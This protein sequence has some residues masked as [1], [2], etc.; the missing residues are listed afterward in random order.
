MDEDQ[1]PAFT[2]SVNSLT[3]PSKVQG[4]RSTT[5]R[6]IATPEARRVLGTEYIAQ[7]GRS[8]TRPVLRIGEGDVDLFRAEVVPVKWTRDVIECLAVGGNASWFEYAKSVKLDKIDLGNSLAPFVPSDT[9]TDANSLLYMALIDFG[10]FDGQPSTYNVTRYMLRAAFRAHLLIDKAFEGSGWTVKANGKLLS[11]WEKII[12][13]DP[14]HDPLTPIMYKGATGK[15][16]GISGPWSVTINELGTTPVATPYEFTGWDPPGTTT[17]SYLV[18]STGTLRVRAENVFVSFDPFDP[19][20]VGT[21]IY[22]Q[23]FDSLTGSVLASTYSVYDPISGQ[24]LFNHTFAAIPVT[25]GQEVKVAFQCEV[26]AYLGSSQD[27]SPDQVLSF[28]MNDDLV[29]HQFIPWTLSDTS[30]WSIPNSTSIQLTGLPPSISL[31]ELITALCADQCIVIDTDADSNTIALWYF[32]EYMRSFVSTSGS[33]DWST[34]LDHSSAP[35]RSADKQLKGVRFRMKEDDEDDLLKRRNAETTGIGY[36]NVDVDGD[37]VGSAM[38]VSLPFAASM[39]DTTFDGVAIPALREYG[40]VAGENNYR[41]QPRIFIDA[42]MVSG[43]WKYN[44]SA[45]STYPRLYFTTSDVD[46]TPVHFGNAD[47]GY[48]GTVAT[49]WANR[50]D[51]MLHGDIL[52]AY[53]HLRDNELQDFDFG[54]PTL[55]DDGSGPA[56]YWVQEIR[57]HRFGAGLPTKVTLVKIPDVEYQ[58]PANPPVEFPDPPVPFVCEGPGTASIVVAPGGGTKLF[59]IDGTSTHFTIR[60]PS[61]TFTWPI[62][63]SD[64]IDIGEGSWCIYASDADGNPGGSIHDLQI[65]MFT[66]NDI[67]SVDL[68]RMNDLRDVYMTEIETAATFAPFNADLENISIGGAELISVLPSFVNVD[69]LQSFSID[70][71]SVLSALPDFSTDA[72]ATFS[73]QSCPS[74]ASIGTLPKINQLDIADTGITDPAVIDALVNALHPASAGVAT[75]NGLLSLRTSAS[76]TNYNACISAGWTII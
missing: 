13:I 33:R 51:T 59:V 55:V 8:G 18:P 27:T 71:M 41:R 73:I 31:A 52:T 65:G 7:V 68:S 61:Q 75:F 56:W 17:Y 24:A 64:G 54:M 19:P 11:V 72:L 23:L 50:L 15:R 45:R 22:M 1:L 48:E 14:S 6:I 2:L 38:D 53:F 60:G 70:N 29:E 16:A 39:N 42:G 62:N 35:E 69:G 58:A 37:G 9:W 5:I 46:R 49:R 34:R 76:D 21:R 26:G 25:S 10:S 63:A 67:M 74:L 28:A 66:E 44:G 47:A 32:D 40:A 4:V 43:N 57:D 12:V 36:G 30:F 3:D 20:T